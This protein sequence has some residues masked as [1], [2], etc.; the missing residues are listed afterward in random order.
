MNR[1]GTVVLSLSK[2]V[3]DFLWH[4]ALLTVHLGVNC[5]VGL[6]SVFPAISAICLPVYT[7]AAQ[8]PILCHTFKIVLLQIVYGSLDLTS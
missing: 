7:W 4:A 5:D 6:S 2:S 8:I 3:K 1:N